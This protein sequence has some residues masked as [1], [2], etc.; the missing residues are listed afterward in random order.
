MALQNIIPVLEEFFF[1]LLS[2]GIVTHF[3]RPF[4]LHIGLL[5]RF[6]EEIQQPF[7]RFCIVDD[8]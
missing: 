6:H 1:G 3:G 7:D 2:D 5:M 8:I 4:Q